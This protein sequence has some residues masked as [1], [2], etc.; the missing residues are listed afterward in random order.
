[1]ITNCFGLFMMALIV[2]YGVYNYTRDST[3]RWFRGCISKD[4][5]PTIRQWSESD[6]DKHL[7]KLSRWEEFNASEFKKFVTHQISPLNLS[8][9]ERFHFLE[10]GVGVGAFAREILHNYPNSTG[11]GFDLEDEAVAIASLVLPPKRMKVFVGNMLDLSFLEPETFDYI[12]MPGSLCYLHSLLDVKITLQ[13]MARIL[14]MH[15]GLCASMLASATS[16]TGSCNTRIPKSFWWHLDGWKVIATQK[17]DD[18]G[19][20][21][22]FG[23]YAVC[24]RKGV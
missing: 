24:L 10:A 11:V 21:H 15:G 6:L 13:Q 4:M 19:L 23:R 20:P 18:W 5:E 3:R 7:Y 22:S 14:K 12:L 1:M 17:M 16:N 2:G 9:H 8:F